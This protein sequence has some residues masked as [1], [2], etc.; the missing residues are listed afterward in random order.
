MFVCRSPIQKK[1]M[2]T[3]AKTKAKG[4]KKSKVS[5][6][7][8]IGKFQNKQFKIIKC[9][10]YAR[11]G[12]KTCKKHTYFSEL[13]D[14]EILKIKDWFEGNENDNVIFCIHCRHFIFDEVGEDNIVKNC[15]ICK[16]KKQNDYA[17]RKSKIIKCKWFDKH[18]NNCRNKP[19]NDTE[20]CD[21]HDYVVNYTEEQRQESAKCSG[22]LKIKYLG[23]YKTCNDCHIRS[24][25]NVKKNKDDIVL[26][27]KDR[28]KFKGGENGYCGKHQYWAWKDEQEKDGLVKVCTNFIRG[29]K[30][31]LEVNSKY[32][33]CDDCKKVDRDRS[34]RRRDCKK[35]EQ[36][37]DNLIACN[38]CNKKYAKDHYIG[39]RGQPVKSCQKC[40]EEQKGRDALRSG[41][42]DRDYRKEWER[43]GDKIKER[44]RKWKEENPQ[45]AVLRNR[46]YRANY[47]G[48][49]GRD[50]YLEKCKRDAK[51]HRE[52]IKESG[53]SLSSQLIKILDYYKRHAK[54]EG[55]DWNL[56]DD[57]AKIMYLQNCEYC[58]RPAIDNN[59][60]GIDRLLSNKDYTEDNV[61]SACSI[62]NTIK[63]CLD[64]YVFFKRVEHILNFNKIEDCELSYD[65]IPDCNSSSYANYILRA[66]KK[67]L[68]FDITID[69]YY[70]LINEECYICGKEATES[71]ANGIDRYTSL[72]GY[73]ADNCRSCCSECNYM[74]NDME[75][76]DFIEQLTLI[77]KHTIDDKSELYNWAIIRWESVNEIPEFGLRH[78]QSSNRNKLSKEKI[79]MNSVIRHIKSLDTFNKATDIE[80]QKKRTEL[81]FANKS[82]KT[83]KN[84]KLKEM[85]E[86]VKNRKLTKEQQD[87]EDRIYFNQ[88]AR[89]SKRKD[90]NVNNDICMDEYDLY[91]EEFDMDNEDF[92]DNSNKT[93]KRKKPGPKPIYTKEER[94]ERN[95]ESKRNYAKRKRDE[96]N[97]NKVI[98]TNEEKLEKRRAAKREYARKRREQ[99][100]AERPAKIPLTLEEKRK[101]Q[102]DATR[103]CRERQK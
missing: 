77:Y 64:P 30:N 17:K 81:E 76:N 56:E 83:K 62:C 15:E 68:D 10:K 3:K 87:K 72:L 98:L 63:G 27:K 88:F 60:N 38:K 96:K 1:I 103:R 93:G 42:P 13:D 39:V 57:F 18:M 44:R 41:R 71:H 11:D 28:C 26:C 2:K 19:T 5:C 54:N 101:R 51:S 94:E 50:E 86:K 22:C 84:S 45:E 31:T 75:Y 92:V 69:D 58:N 61:A 46:I 33:R 102:R 36:D 79:A 55:I 12:A 97:L 37:D 73:T 8:Y 47:I 78:K 65:L 89:K 91:I 95:R 6:I 80:Y 49:L 74:K 23:N 100:R 48:K 9:P 16:L 29:C 32:S 25:K 21:I 34:K 24:D 40:R 7:A 53:M 99:E 90:E 4:N 20:Y 14:E 85:M 35:N 43:K 52:K 70:K 66:A 67:E 82:N 59:L